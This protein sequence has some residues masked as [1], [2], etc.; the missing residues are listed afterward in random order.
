MSAFSLTVAIVDGTRQRSTVAV[1]PTAQPLI[2]AARLMTE[3]AFRIKI[4]LH[5]TL[6]YP[7]FR[8]FTIHFLLYIENR[9]LRS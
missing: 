6:L 1:C 8:V 5:S 3:A 2:T 4:E 9:I 7:I